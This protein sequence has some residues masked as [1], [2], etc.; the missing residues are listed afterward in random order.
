MII[1]SSL[2]ALLSGWSMWGGCTQPPVFTSVA[3]VVIQT[4]TPGGIS[5]EALK[6]DRLERAKTCL[7]NT[8]EIQKDQGKPELLQEILLIQVK[9]RYADRVFEFVTDENLKGNKGKFYR[10]TCLYRIIK[11]AKEL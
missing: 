9:D 11:N 6:G 4:Q 5:R 2:H 1:A 7:Y 10:N 3:E 8:V